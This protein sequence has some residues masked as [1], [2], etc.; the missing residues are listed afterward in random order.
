M[1]PGEWD[2]EGGTRAEE[3]EKPGQVPAWSMNDGEAGG[4][5]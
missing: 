4:P 2:L 3:A 5:R 1:R